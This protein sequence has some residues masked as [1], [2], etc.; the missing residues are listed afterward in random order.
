MDR[1]SKIWIVIFVVIVTIGI[2]SVVY[3][4][5]I[6]NTWEQKTK[7]GI[8][9]EIILYNSFPNDELLITFQDGTFMLVTQNHFGTYAILSQ[10]PIGTKIKIDYKENTFN[11][12][13]YVESI[14]VIE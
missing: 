10:T 3:F 4:G 8:F 1:I 7:I 13:I 11:N 6:S 14:E 12:K 5:I 2:S 9:N